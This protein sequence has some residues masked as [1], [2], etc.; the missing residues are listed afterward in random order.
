MDLN[1]R[2]NSQSDSTSEENGVRSTTSVAGWATYNAA[3][4]VDIT[5]ARPNPYFGKL[6]LAFGIDNI[7]DVEYELAKIGFYQPGRSYWLSLQYDF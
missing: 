4:G 5:P 6:T 2:A 1:V 3:F 7:T